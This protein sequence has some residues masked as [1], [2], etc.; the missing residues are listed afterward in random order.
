MKQILF[1]STVWLFT[2]CSGSVNQNRGSETD[3]AGVTIK[4]NS[5]VYYNGDIITMEGDTTQ[6]AEALVERDEKMLYAGSKD[7]AMKKAV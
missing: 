5:T 4:T 3:S 7:E 1:I 6:Y 2:A